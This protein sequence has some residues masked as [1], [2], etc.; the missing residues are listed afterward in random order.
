MTGFQV[1]TEPEQAALEAA[2]AQRRGNHI[3]S[4]GCA[5]EPYWHWQ[6]VC[7][8]PVTKN[9]LC[10]WHNNPRPR[11]GVCG[12]FVPKGGRCPDT[13][14]LWEYSAWEHR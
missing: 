10:R 12:K 14:F 7:P 3:A 5:G 11:C 4:G 2:K 9:G 1:I 8:K 13:Y 6:E